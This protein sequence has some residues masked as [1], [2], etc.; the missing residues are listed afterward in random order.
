MPL[1]F[2]WSR[3]IT[4]IGLLLHEGFKQ[5]HLGHQHIPAIALP[6]VHLI[7]GIPTSF[8]T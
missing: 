1:H 5:L 7:I 2:S 6:K 3:Q 4:T 8:K